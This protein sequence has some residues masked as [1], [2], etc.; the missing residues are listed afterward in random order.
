MPHDIIS[1]MLLHETTSLLCLPLGRDRDA[2]KEIAIVTR[3]MPPQL[4]YRLSALILWRQQGL[5]AAVDDGCL[6][7]GQDV[8]R[9]AMQRCKACSAFAATMLLQKRIVNAEQGSFVVNVL[10]LSEHI[11]AC[12][13]AATHG[14]LYS[15]IAMP[16]A[17]STESLPIQIYEA[18]CRAQ[19]TSCAIIGMCVTVSH[20]RGLIVTLSPGTSTPQSWTTLPELP[21]ALLSP[22]RA[23][24]MHDARRCHQHQQPT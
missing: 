10:S 20:L 17:T 7:A 18:C 12:A 21:V 9:R 4:T 6:H 19:V 16:L 13:A 14:S 8:R 1:T 15:R 2:F 24:V 3:V 22:E 23:R 11:A 5:R